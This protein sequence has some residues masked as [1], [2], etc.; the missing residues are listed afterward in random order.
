VPAARCVRAASSARSRCA[1]D[2]L[3]W[4]PRAT[5][6]PKRCG[7]TTHYMQRTSLHPAL[8]ATMH[9]LRDQEDSIAPATVKAAHT[10]R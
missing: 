3:R 1:A 9:D 5:R 10:G 2:G 4:P 7:P 6:D 8:K